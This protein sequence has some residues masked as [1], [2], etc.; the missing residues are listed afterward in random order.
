MANGEVL[1]LTP[2][3][4]VS[5]GDRLLTEP[6]EVGAFLKGTV[7]VK[8]MDASGDAALDVE[9]LISPYGYEEE[10]HW[11]SAESL[12]GLDSEGMYAIP[13]THLGNVARLA[14]EV[15][16][17]SDGAVTVQAWCVGKG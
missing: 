14:L 17:Q 13:M 1:P 16:D 9:V 5:P 4:T 12:S 10:D 2:D 15:D 3:T 6:T 8:M 7:F 11:A